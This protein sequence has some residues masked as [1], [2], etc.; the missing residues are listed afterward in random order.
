MRRSTRGPHRYVSGAGHT[1]VLQLFYRGL[2]SG[3]WSRWRNPNGSWSEGTKHRRAG[4]AVTSRGPHDS[5][6]TRSARH[7]GGGVTGRSVDGVP[8]MQ[9]APGDNDVSAGTTSEC[10]SFSRPIGGPDAP[11]PPVVVS[12]R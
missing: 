12:C 5:F 4:S 8:S 7:P 10:V 1:A 9:S 11:V 2:D 6:G 3:V